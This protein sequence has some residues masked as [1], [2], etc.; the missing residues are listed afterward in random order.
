MADAGGIQ[1]DLSL[2]AQAFYREVRKTQREINRSTQQM[3]RD[4]TTLNSRVAS[5]ARGMAV[6]AAAIAGAFVIREIGQ[7]IGDVARAGERLEVLQGQMTALTGDATRGAQAVDQVFDVISRTGQSLD[8][9]ISQFSRFTLATRELGST[10]EEVAQFVENLQQLGRIGG[11]NTQEIA[12]ASIQLA[13][14]LASGRLQGE[15]LRSVLEQLPLVARAIADEMGVGIGEMRELASEGRIT[16][17]VVMRALLSRTEEI[18]EQAATL[19]VTMEQAGNKLNAAWTRFLATADE[20]VGIS[21]IVADILQ[22]A[23]YNLNQITAGDFGNFTTLRQFDRAIDDQIET[24]RELKRSLEEGDLGAGAYTDLAIQLQAAQEELNKLLAAQARFVEANGLTSAE[25]KD[26]VKE[27]ATSW[28]EL[29]GAAQSFLDNYKAGQEVVTLTL[30]E[31]LA[32]R[33]EEE[34]RIQA[35]ALEAE[36]LAEAEQRAAAA[37]M[38]RLAAF[39]DTARRNMDPRIDLEEDFAMAQKAFNEGLLTQAQL[40]QFNAQRWEEYRETILR[41]TKAVE[42][43]TKQTEEL[44]DIAEELGLTFSSAFEDA[45]IQGEGLREVLKGIAQDIL[46][47]YVRT[48]ITKPA[49]G[50]FGDLFNTGLGALTGSLFGGG[51]AGLPPT[52]F[53]GGIGGAIAKGAAFDGGVQAL[54]KGGLLTSRTKFLADGGTYLA[55][56]AGT[57]AIMPLE[58]DG[59]GRLGVIVSREQG[60]SGEGIQV[61]QNIN[62]ETGVAQTVRAEILNLLPTLD[63][64]TKAVIAD[65]Q[66]RNGGRPI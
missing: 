48:Q 12:A 60:S 14:G 6:S 47:I 58:R 57:E 50:F 36:K 9:T 3:S 49:A 32:L 41:G 8:G 17:D 65:A 29:N 33:S 53:G 63:E 54:A 19:P 59:R 7:F 42:E 22:G 25:I 34:K 28:R 4:F 56:E 43:S 40:I 55:G 15:E 16:A 20:A 66:Q 18:A 26:S 35:A 61:V 62:I 27:A 11:A 10:N 52:T 39:A 1:I 64:R 45:I 23:A 13:Q 51:G 46:R 2:E 24:I 37:A 44:N 38:A 5:V 30:K 21:K 31:R